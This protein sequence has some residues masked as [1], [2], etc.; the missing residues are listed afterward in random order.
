MKKVILCPG[1][2]GPQLITLMSRMSRKSMAT[3][4][5]FPPW[6]VFPAQVLSKSSF[7]SNGFFSLLFNEPRYRQCKGSGYYELADE[8]W[9]EALGLGKPCTSCRR[10]TPGSSSEE[11]F[12]GGLFH[13]LEY[14]CTDLFAGSLISCLNFTRTT[15]SHLSSAKRSSV[16]RSFSSTAFRIKW[17]TS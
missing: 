8:I 1:S 17:N 6:R 5:W 2:S 4:T 15:F 13:N 11:S 3:M 10:A 14:W 16:P 9:R 7:P 12:H